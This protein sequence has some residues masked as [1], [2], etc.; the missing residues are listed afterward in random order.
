MFIFSAGT[1]KVCK[2]QMI[3]HGLLA[4]YFGVATL[5]RWKLRTILVTLS[6]CDGL[7]I[8]PSSSGKRICLYLPPL[9]TRKTALVVTRTIIVMTNKVAK[10]KSKE[11]SRAKG[12]TFMGIAQVDKSRRQLKG[13]SQLC[14]QYLRH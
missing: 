12:S 4:K 7:V 10:L 11:F 3:L 5:H 13:S 2:T 8:Q 6:G 9:V 14:T 1:A